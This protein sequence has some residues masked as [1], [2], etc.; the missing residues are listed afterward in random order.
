M[1]VVVGVDQPLSDR[2]VVDGLESVWQVCFVEVYV[3][4]LVLV[5]VDF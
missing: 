2:V 1:G 4:S 3:D 5:Y